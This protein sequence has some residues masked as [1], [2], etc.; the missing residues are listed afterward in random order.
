MSEKWGDEVHRNVLDYCGTKS[1]DEL[2]SHIHASVGEWVKD[3]K[4]SY[5]YVWIQICEGNF[6]TR[7]KIRVDAP[8]R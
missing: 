2:K 1:C 7:R 6:C 3:G 8:K 5:T 4:D